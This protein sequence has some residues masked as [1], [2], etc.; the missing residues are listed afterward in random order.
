M[1]CA[2]HKN[3]EIEKTAKYPAHSRAS[4]AEKRPPTNSRSIAGLP[5][6]II[7]EPAS[8]PMQVTRDTESA[9]VLANSKRFCFAHR[10]AKK[11]IEAAPAACASIDMGAVNSRFA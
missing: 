9:T 2:D 1:D 11:G 5:S 8:N 7:A 6:A 4:A 10:L 3:S